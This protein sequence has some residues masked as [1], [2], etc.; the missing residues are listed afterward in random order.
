MATP[1]FDI[2]LRVQTL[3]E[4]GTVLD[5]RTNTITV[6][7]SI[8]PMRNIDN[9]SQKSKIEKAWSLNNSVMVHEPESTLGATN[10]VVHILDANYE[11]ADLQ[12]VV[13]DN[14][15]DLA[16][17]EQNKL[18]DL[19]TEYE[20][21]FD[22]TLG[23]WKTEPVSLEIKDGA[24]PYHGRAFPVPKIHK[25]TLV[26]E[27]NRLCKLGVLEFQPA[28]EWAAPSFIIPKQDQTVRVISDFRELNKRLVRK[29]FPIP[30]IS[31]VLQ[32]MEGF[33]FATAL[34]LNM[35]YYTIRLDPDASKI[36]TIIFPWGKYSYLRLPML[37]VLLIF[38]N[39]KC[40][41]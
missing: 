37:Q 15:K 11:K 13:R 36:C 10:R 39:Q 7:E 23:D 12:S 18:L 8:L 2:I 25:A 4:L 6:D 21:L 5:F 28:S 38:F 26:N 17:H 30:K 24:K 3:K 14:C 1:A 29:P 33:T 40:W 31:T 19:L 35:G 34:D 16:L 32:E 22:C 41:N 27:L 20:D 9:L